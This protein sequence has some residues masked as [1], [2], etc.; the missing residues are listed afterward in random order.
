MKNN[1]GEITIIVMLIIMAATAFASQTKWNT[2]YEEAI[3]VANDMP[4]VQL[5]YSIAGVEDK[6][7]WDIPTVR[8]RAMRLAGL[9]DY[10]GA[11]IA[12]DS[13]GNWLYIL[14]D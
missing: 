2:G 5:Y 13:T 7:W 10:Q 3:Y 8:D 9:A 1:R 6:V 4:K 11:D 14:G 12:C